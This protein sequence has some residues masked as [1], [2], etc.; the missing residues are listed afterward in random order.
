MCPGSL[1]HTGLFAQEREHKG[2]GG[3]QAVARC[4]LGAAVRAAD[5]VKGRAIQ[6]IQIH[7]SWDCSNLLSQIHVHIY[8][9]EQGQNKASQFEEGKLKV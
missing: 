2:A 6:G 9:R 7:S 4:A 5:L 1:A 8:P 3:R